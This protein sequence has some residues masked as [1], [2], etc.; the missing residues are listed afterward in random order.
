MSKTDRK[1][2]T[3][4]YTYDALNRLT[5][6]Q[7]PDSTGVSYTYDALSR[8]TQV[9]D[10]TGTYGFT[11]DNLS[12]LLG[13]GTQ[14]AFLLE[15]TLTLGYSYDAASNRLS[16]TNP[17]GGVT[18]YAYDSLNR[19]TGI[20]DFAG[21]VFG[22]SYD[23]L[24]RRT[25]LTRPNGVNTTYNYDPLSRLLS[26]LHQAGSVTLDGVAYAY[27]AAGNRTAKTVLPAGLTSTYAY[28]PTYQL[29]RVTRSSDA[30]ITERYT[31]DAVD[32]R[33]Y[34]PGAPYT[35]NESN[36][37]TSRE[38]VPYTYDANGNTTSKT[39]RD[40]T[41]SYAW[42]FENRLTS[43][44]K[45]DGTVVSFQYDPF[46]RR[47]RKSSPT[48]T[49]IYVYDGDNI[50]EE[51]NA[52][53]NLGERYT[54]GPGIDEPLVGQRQPL[55]FYYEADGLGS[56][57]S[58][59]NPDGT[60][61]ATYTYESFGFL[62]ESTGSATNWFRYTA[63]QFDSSTAL[64]YYR[65]RYYDPM[66]GR[67]LS[68][69]PIGTSGALDLY[70]Y[71]SN[72]PVNRVDA[73]GLKE[74]KPR[75][76]EPNP[77]AA[78]YICRKKEKPAICE[79]N[80]ATDPWIKQ[81]QEEHE[82]QHIRDIEKGCVP[83]LGS[84]PCRGAANGVPVLVNLAQSAFLECRG[85]CEQLKCLRRVFQSSAVRSTEEQVQKQIGKYCGAAGCDAK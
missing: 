52:S 36:Q 53:G 30:K 78:Y 34:Q 65:A 23:A 59:T 15:G 55:I 18:N 2:Q 9:T 19:L 75:P 54:Q 85:Y 49:T 1:G 32:N 45:P 58:L 35:Y 38:G 10:P 84:N 16:L 43:V 68:E 73:F 3:I 22:F 83:G 81:C 76:P 24:G 28:D 44:T 12:R 47:I 56:I 13:T 25:A 17:Q 40:G 20:T 82:R 11:Y 4:G 26:V 60:V 62:R 7:Y 39:N 72:N 61:A 77:N 21:R 71:V 64:Y 46:G 57:T 29:T 42:D 66:T 51:L 50:N 41:T 69:D 33:L 80:P 74:S 63:R 48:G 27:D 6:K 37:M 67:F 5:R 8:L 14:Y 31:Y 70:L 79:R